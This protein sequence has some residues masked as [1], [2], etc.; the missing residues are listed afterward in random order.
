MTK[1]YLRRLFRKKPIPVFAS[2]WFKLGDE[3]TETKVAAVA[4]AGYRLSTLEGWQ[5][6]VPG[7]WIVG[8]GHRGEFWVV[9]NDI[10][11]AT[12]EEIV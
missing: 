1:T 3:P 6:I 11:E 12:Y 4:D 8:P 2:Q 7:N 10:F 9:Q 5:D